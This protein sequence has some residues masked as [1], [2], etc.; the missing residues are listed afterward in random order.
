MRYANSN[1]K[2]VKRN[3]KLHNPDSPL[4]I[5]DV[6]CRVSGTGHIRLRLRHKKH[7]SGNWINRDPAAVADTTSGN[8]RSLWCEDGYIIAYDPSWIFTDLYSS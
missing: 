5:G 1:M 4:L 2:L 8:V 7:T 6:K 3:Q